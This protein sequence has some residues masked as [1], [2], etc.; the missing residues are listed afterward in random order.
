MHT[1]QLKKN[2]ERRLLKGHQWIFSNE[3]TSI[4]KDIPSGEIVKLVSHDNRF[5]G[6]GFYNPHSLIAFRLLS[7]NDEAIN[8][9]FF[10]KRLKTAL[11]FRLLR[12]PSNITNAFRLIHS[13]SDFMPGLVIDKF[14]DIISIQT[15]SMGMELWLEVLGELLKEQ[16]NPRMI[17]LRNE[18]QLRIQ[19]GLGT[20]KKIVLGELESPKTLIHSYN[21]SYEIDAVEGQKTGFFLDQRENRKRIEP[22]SKN[23]NMLDVFSNDGGF[24]LHALHADAKNVTI[25]DSS[26]TAIE[27]SINNFKLNNLS[28]Y[29]SIQDDA[30]DAL[31]KLI[32]QGKNYDLIVLDPPSLTKSKKA[33]P[34]AIRA[35]KKLNKMCLQLLKNGG[36]LATASCSHHVFEDKFFEIINHSAQELRVQ[37]RLLEKGFQAPDHPVLTMMPETQYLKFAI[38]QKC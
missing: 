6:V 27:R 11:D 17:V 15:F 7:R 28:N 4:P 33:L 3:L 1:I 12:Y 18:S 19:E 32:Q 37:L 2:E 30:F 22:Y 26:E 16:F 5:V 35:Y 34:N 14:N 21:I 10:K 23:A 31:K 25:I 38:F 20:Y 36:I 24:A 9:E 8:D 29:D 13:E